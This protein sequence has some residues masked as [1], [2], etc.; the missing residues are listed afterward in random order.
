MAD[1]INCANNMKQLALAIKMYEGDYGMF[2]SDRW[3]D[4]LLADIGLRAESSNNITTIFRCP[5]ASKKQKSSYAMNRN[6][7]GI[8]DNDK[9]SPDTVLLFES[10]TGWN[11]TGGPEIASARHYGLRLNVALVDGSVEDIELKDI[12]NL[13]WNP[14]TNTPS[15]AVK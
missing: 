13:R 7:V 8:K 15:S 3:C 1:E 4:T 11:A 10:D 14:Y 5:T 2:P 9:I 12:G 6:L